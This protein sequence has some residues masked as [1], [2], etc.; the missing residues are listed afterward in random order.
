MLISVG[1]IRKTYLYHGSYE[2]ERDF[3]DR[4]QWFINDV[5]KD[6]NKVALL[7]GFVDDDNKVLAKQVKVLNVTFSEESLQERLDRVKGGGAIN[8]CERIFMVS[9]G[10]VDFRHHSRL[11]MEKA[12]NKGN[13]I[14]PFGLPSW[15]LETETWKLSVKC[16][17]LLYGKHARIAVGGATPGIDEGDSKLKKPD[18]EV[19]A[20]FFHAWPM[21]LQEELAFS[22][23][24]DDVF[25]MTAGPPDLALLCCRNRNPYFGITLT[26]EHDRA[27]WTEL[28][29]RVFHSMCKEG[30]KLY[31]ARLAEIVKQ[32]GADK[33]DPSI[34][35]TPSKK[36]KKSANNKPKKG[37]KVADESDEDSDEESD[38]AEEGGPKEK[39]AKKKQ[40]AKDKATKKKKAEED[41]EGSGKKHKALTSGE[42]MDKIRKSH[43]S[44]L[45]EQV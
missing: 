25:D 28:P 3:G 16:K 23:D 31:E 37:E 10:K 33:K 18:H 36:R 27:F 39:E 4:D 38:S 32:L 44:T 17:K 20:V 35:K 22:Y 19:E 7:G 11:H 26:E 14:G 43:V 13:F 1:C 40:A 2:K 8:Q 9:K 15:D 41:I 24:I 6:G 45:I 34:K 21:A 29:L 42:L 5:G 12:S 30:N